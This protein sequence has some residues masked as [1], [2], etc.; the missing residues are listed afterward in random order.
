MKTSA[1]L[2]DGDH[3][4]LKYT[5]KDVQTMMKIPKAFH[6]RDEMNRKKIC[7]FIDKYHM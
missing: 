7:Y 6:L 1:E 3:N 5:A 4:K 2:A